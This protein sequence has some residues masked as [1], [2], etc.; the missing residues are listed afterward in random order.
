MHLFCVPFVFLSWVSDPPTLLSN[1][2]CGLDGGAGDDDDEYD[3]CDDDYGVD[4]GGDD[5]SEF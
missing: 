1:G 3:D 2:K 5:D 4:D